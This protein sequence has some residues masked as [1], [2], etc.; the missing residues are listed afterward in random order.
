M[1][2]LLDVDDLGQLLDPV[3]QEVAL[4]DGVIVQGAL[5]ISPAGAKHDEATGYMVHR[6][7]VFWLQHPVSARSVFSVDTAEALG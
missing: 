2:D 1:L 6:N 7:H 5:G 4:L 3:E